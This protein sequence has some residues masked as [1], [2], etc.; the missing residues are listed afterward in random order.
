MLLPAAAAL[1]LTVAL[2]APGRAATRLPGLSTFPTALLASALDPDAP[3]PGADDWGCRPSPAHPRPVVLVHGTFENAFDNWNALSPELA[4]AGYC[5]FAIDYGEQTPHALLKGEADIADSARQLAVF[6]DRVR[7]T[8]GAA[9]VDL[10]GHS[11]GGGVL[12]RQYL[13]FD[14]GAAS[15]DQAENKV[16]SLIGINPSN[17]GTALAGLFT[18]AREVGLGVVTDQVLGPAGEQ[19]AIGSALNTRLDR[20]GDT[21][22]GVQYTVIASRADEVILPYT[23]SFL[24]AGPG[25]TVRNLTLQDLCPTDLSDHLGSPYDPLVAHLVLNALDPAHATPPPCL[26]ALPVLG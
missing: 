20:G 17:H 11:Q 12:P 6:V 19:Q 15:G 8:T 25:A 1:A 10:V 13:K 16:H 14:D 24:T 26:P 4:E 3:P 7:R 23:Q 2:A 18:L 5:V 21:V 22:P 9:Q